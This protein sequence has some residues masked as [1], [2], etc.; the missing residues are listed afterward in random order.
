MYQEVIHIQKKKYYG[1][2]FLIRDTDC[3][4]GE[5]CPIC[6]EQYIPGIYKRTLSCGHYF[7]KKCIDEWFKRENMDCP[8]CRKKHNTREF[9][10][11]SVSEKSLQDLLTTLR[12]SC[13]QPVPLPSEK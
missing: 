9:F 13:Q 5:E 10:F 4:V 8:L 12:I 11:R 2:Y 6:L 7:H 3:I 1:K